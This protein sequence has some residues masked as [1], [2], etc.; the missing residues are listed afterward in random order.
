MANLIT[1]L[2]A[3]RIS[4][5]FDYVGIYRQTLN[6][7]ITKAA[8]KGETCAMTTVLFEHAQ[9]LSARLTA[10]GY[11]VMIVPDCEGGPLV[12]KVDWTKAVSYP[13]AVG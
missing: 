13:C 4:E 12:I 1:P 7:V 6:D 8:G 11:D 5:K 3:K 9:G 10:M 2:E